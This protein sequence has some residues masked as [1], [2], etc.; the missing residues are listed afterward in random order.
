MTVSR[1]G[2]SI[3]K[4]TRVVPGR[5]VSHGIGFSIFHTMP[6]SRQL[7]V[8]RASDLRERTETEKDGEHTE[9]TVCVTQSWSDILPRL[10]C[11]SL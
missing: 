1:L 5:P 11:S 9:A 4:L 3:S 8:L 7:A 10:P 6:H 2:R